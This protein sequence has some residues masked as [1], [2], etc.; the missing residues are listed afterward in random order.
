[1]GVERTAAL[2][3]VRKAAKR[4]RYTGELASDVLGRRAA[5]L[6]RAMEEVQDALGEGQDSAVTRQLCLS[7]GIAASAAGENAWTY[8][9]LHGLEQ[10]RADRAERAFWELAPSLP[11]VLRR[12]AAKS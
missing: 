2:H 12:A 8:G 1:V 9:R 6:V 7:V 5:K 11:R 4:A 10:A 3:Q